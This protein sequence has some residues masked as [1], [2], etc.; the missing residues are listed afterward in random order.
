[1]RADIETWLTFLE[2]F[3]GVTSYK[4]VDWANDF[5]V[6]L[7]TE[8]AGSVQFRCGAILGQQ[9]AFMQ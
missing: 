9:W 5:D 1:M 8:S 3:N 6:E 4:A 7:F 2:C